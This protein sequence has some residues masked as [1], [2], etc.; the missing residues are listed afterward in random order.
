MTCEQDAVIPYCRLC[1]TCYEDQYINVKSCQACA[2][3]VAEN[4]MCGY[5]LC[6]RCVQTTDTFWEDEDE[7][8]DED[9]NQNQNQKQNQNENQNQKQIQDQNEGW[10]DVKIKKNK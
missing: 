8:E 9:E 4:D 5:F 2:D 3:P 6:D 10:Q 7:S 1:E